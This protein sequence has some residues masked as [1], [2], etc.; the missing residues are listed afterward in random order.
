ML[1]ISPAPGNYYKVS[2]IY[3]SSLCLFVCLSVCIFCLRMFYCG[4]AVIWM[5]AERRCCSGT[6]L[7][8]FHYVPSLANYLRLVLYFVNLFARFGAVLKLTMMWHNEVVTTDEKEKDLGVIIHQTL[9]SNSQCVAAVN[10]A[11]RTLGMIAQL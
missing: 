10:S 3:L 4:Y 7:F 11:N 8:A 5:S 1:K 6:I 2:Y 9:K